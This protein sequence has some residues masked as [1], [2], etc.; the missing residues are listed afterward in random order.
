MRHKSCGNGSKNCVA[1]RIAMRNGIVIG[2]PSFQA[3]QILT[4][5]QGGPPLR[6]LRNNSELGKEIRADLKQCCNLWIQYF[7]F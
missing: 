4:A 2:N 1:F 6:F 5:Y 3:A 7:D